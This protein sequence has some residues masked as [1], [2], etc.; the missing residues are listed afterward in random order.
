MHC[1]S[2]A[3]TRPLYASPRS[4]TNLIFTF[5]RRLPIGGLDFNL[6]C[7]HLQE[8][9][10][11]Y[12]LTSGQKV[13]LLKSTLYYSLKSIFGYDIKS[14]TDLRLWSVVRPY[15]TWESLSPSVDQG[16]PSA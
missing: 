15:K 16:G 9:L 1:I 10:E 2:G 4:P 7:H 5:Y 11:K 6:E 13:N 3:N 12:C 8:V 14:G